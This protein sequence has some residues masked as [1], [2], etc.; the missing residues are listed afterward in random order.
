MTQYETNNGLL[1][2]WRNQ[3]S[4]S[5]TTA[6]GYLNFSGD[7]LRSHTVCIATRHWNGNGQLVI[8]LTTSDFLMN[9]FIKGMVDSLNKT[10][11]YLPII[12]KEVRKVS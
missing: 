11:D 2:A 3:D 10:A 12:L 5:G 9:M 8:T 6:N 4:T 7:N 1:N